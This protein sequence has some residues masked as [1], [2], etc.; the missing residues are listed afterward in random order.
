MPLNPA[1]KLIF[2]L[3]ICL[4]AQLTF[5]DVPI[6]PDRMNVFTTEENVQFILP[7][8]AG[9][10]VSICDSLGKTMD[11]ICDSSGKVEFGLLTTGC[12]RIKANGKD[13]GC[14][15]V[16]IPKSR[17]PNDTNT[18]IGL[19]YAM[20]TAGFPLDDKLIPELKRA[21]SMA[22]KA[23]VK[24]VRER[25][26]TSGQKKELIRNPD[27]SFSIDEQGWTSTCLKINKA[28]GFSVCAVAQVSPPSI[29]IDRNPKKVPDSLK[30]TYALYTAIGSA[31]GPLLEGIELGNEIDL[32]T[33]YDG[34][35]GEY[36]AYVKTAS[37]ALRSVNPSLLLVQSSFARPAINLKAAL[38]E[39]G[40]QNFCD[41][42]NYH[43]YGETGKNMNDY[44]SYIISQESYSRLWCTETGKDIGIWDWNKAGITDYPPEISDSIARTLGSIYAENL[45]AGAEKVYY[46]YW[47]YGAELS[48]GSILDKNY[49]ATERYAA[50]ASINRMLGNAIYLGSKID[51]TT[52]AHLFADGHG[53]Q[54]FL[55]Y[56]DQDNASFTI[57]AK[58]PWEL[59]RYT[60]ELIANGE[61]D[62]EIRLS[63]N[64]KTPVYLRISSLL[65][66]FQD[67]RRQKIQKHVKSIQTQA[68]VMELRPDTKV[69]YD[70]SLAAFLLSPGEECPLTLSIHNFGNKTY[71]E[72]LSL[73]IPPPWK[74]SPDSIDAE[75][76]AGDM[77]TVKAI[78][79]APSERNSGR[80]QESLRAEAS[81]LSPA[82]IRLGLAPEKITAKQSQAAFS[83]LNSGSWTCA[84]NASLFDFQVSKGQTGPRF[85]INFKNSGSR[86]FWPVMSCLP[87]KM[88]SLNWGDWEAVKVR[89]LVHSTRPGT[90][91]MLYATELKGARYASNRINADTPGEH[92]LIFPFSF[93]SYITENSA[94]DAPEFSF[95]PDQIKTFGLGSNNSN[96]MTVKDVNYTVDYEIMSIDL[97]K[98]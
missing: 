24:R 7:Q 73:R 22:Q 36:A 53:K 25:L 87:D 21:A 80:L 55:I 54:T 94:P 96:S 46:F 37:F 31:W 64:A 66:S 28:A 26:R 58:G 61:A 40:L 60:G 42:F 84:T 39:N 71:K 12:Y 30:D 89:L 76:Q 56:N 49:M 63:L 88:S 47:R 90:W 62:G 29:N 10:K 51:D 44:A 16:T 27:G 3:I 15:V 23:G 74:I 2:S 72:H 82:A 65:D 86:M 78:I 14:L 18:S 8:A 38:A 98:Y 9:Q 97:M 33:F 81:G 20:N 45:A 50:L 17:Y 11:S 5:S 79:K 57:K 92:E 41:I 93:F 19:D 85:R 68:V 48:A 91:F 70:N 34:T 13:V 75:I 59:L 35:A 77:I 1:M 83:D 67:L 95:N 43:V 32:K 4:L 69:T 52:R 6:F